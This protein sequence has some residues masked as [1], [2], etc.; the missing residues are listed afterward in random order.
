[1][2]F[3]RAVGV[4]LITA[5]IGTGLAVFSADYL[6]KLYHVSDMEGGR[7]MV[8]IF[9]FAPLGFIVGFIIGFVVSLLNR[10]PG[11][12][13]FAKTQGLSILI[14]TALAGLVSGSLYLAADKP[15]TLGGKELTLDFE[16]RLPP[17]I[18]LPAELTDF[19]VRVLL[20]G[21]G[22]SERY[23]EID[24]KSIAQQDGLTTIP[25]TVALTSHR[26]E[27]EL[28]ASIGKRSQRNA[29]H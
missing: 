13:G 19:N 5:I 28:L 12:V 7:G 1:M 16:L 8:V 22:R 24:M 10:W 6:T 14:T 21:Y 29:I 20:Y 15:P 2:R 25:G 3:L 17:T 18:Q 4:G 9:L 23:A 26:P 11:S 27:R